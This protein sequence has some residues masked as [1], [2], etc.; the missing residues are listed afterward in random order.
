MGIAG[1]T[2]IATTTQIHTHLDPDSL[3]SSVD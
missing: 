1:H 3:R 2:N